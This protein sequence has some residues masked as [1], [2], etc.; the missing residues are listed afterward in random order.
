MQERREN[1]LLFVLSLVV[2][3]LLWVQVQPLERIDRQR[4]IV[5]ALELRNLPSSLVVLEPPANVVVVAEGA[6]AELNS[7]EPESL[8]AF[9]DLA[10]AQPGRRSLPVQ[11]I[12]PVRSPVQFMLPRRNVDLVIEPKVSR[13]L[14]VEI[15]TSG[16]PPSEYEYDGASIMPPKVVVTG[17]ESM[18]KE[19]KRARVLLDLSRVRPGAD[20]RLNV[21]VLAD[22]NVPVPSVMVEPSSVNV[23]PGIAAAPATKR[24]I[25]VPNFRGQP[26]FGYQVVSYEIVPPQVQ[27]KGE[28]AELAAVTTIETEPISLS[29]LREATTVTT[30][31][32]LPDGVQ[33]VR[34]TDV[35]VIVRIAPNPEG[36]R[37]SPPPQTDA[38]EATTP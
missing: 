38:P 32:R 1:V 27:L 31:L 28:S 4:E 22:G 18:L 21:E 29:G 6:Q 37:P 24:A 25:V 33:F 11:F 34:E 12:G 3:V 13:E 10:S 17:P 19:A 16:S 30:R 20:F 36:D 8:I 9:V 15:E 2:S 35:R 7:I 14:Q 23:S 26:P 5:V